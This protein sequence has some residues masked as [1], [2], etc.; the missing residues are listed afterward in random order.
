MPFLAILSVLSGALRGAGDTRTTLFITFAGLLGVRLPLAA[1]FACEQVTIP[2]VGIT[3]AG[4]NLGVFGAWYA[5]V[6]DV[7]LRSLLVAARFSHGG[8]QRVRV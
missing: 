1:W 5:M 3:L 4:W 6:A 7:V 2:L 8:W